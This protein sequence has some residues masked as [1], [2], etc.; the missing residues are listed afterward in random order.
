MSE[1]ERID[2]IEKIDK[3]LNEIRPHLAVDGGDVEVIDVTDGKVV[4]IK[5]IGN[6]ESCSMSEMTLR[7]GIAETIKSKMP[8]IV[9]VEAI[10]GNLTS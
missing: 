2:Y 7:A 8:Q 10:N 1:K 4:K 5:W 9:A 3:I 6:C